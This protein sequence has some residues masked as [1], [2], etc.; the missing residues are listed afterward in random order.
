MEIIQV[1]VTGRRKRRMLEEE[2]VEYEYSILEIL[3]K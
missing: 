3:T 1:N 2:L